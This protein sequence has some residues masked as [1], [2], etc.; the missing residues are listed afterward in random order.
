V[1]AE[2]RRVAKTI[3]FGVAY[4]MSPFGLAQ[5]LRIGQKE[6]RSFI[7]AYFARYRGVEN[8]IKEA[9]ASAREKG[10]VRTLLGRR[11]QIP[12]INSRNNAARQFAE[13]TA[14]NTPIQGTAA[15]IIKV[16]MI[17]VRD[18]L[19]AGGYEA[20]MIMQVHDELILEAP[21]KEAVGVIPL[22]KEK[23]ERAVTLSVPLVVNVRS[24]HNW[25]ELE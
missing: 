15:D 16:A 2:M 7:D 13:R 3:N 20:R 4:G 10:Y 11:R 17:Q 24:G 6:A 9:S 25:A 12:D 14:V 1:T 5:E 8:F 18:A 19:S 23:M 22:V 21:E